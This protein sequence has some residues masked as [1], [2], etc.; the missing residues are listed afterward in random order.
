LPQI[1]ILYRYNSA[2]GEAIIDVYQL[3]S[4][5]PLCGY[6]ADLMMNIISC[7]LHSILTITLLKLPVVYHDNPCQD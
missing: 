3:T 1:A 4:D 2:L 7:R 6:I 5:I